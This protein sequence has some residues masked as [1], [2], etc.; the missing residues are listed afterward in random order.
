MFRQFALDGTPAS[1]I[2]LSDE[3]TDVEA[4][5][6][7]HLRDAAVIGAAD[8]L[9]PVSI[10]TGSTLA[11]LIATAWACGTQMDSRFCCGY[12]SRGRKLA[13]EVRP[14]HLA[15]GVDSELA[16]Y[17]VHWTRTRNSAWPDERLIDY[18]HDIIRSESYC[19]SALHTLL[20]ILTTRRILAS[21]RHMPGRTATVSFSALSPG[22]LVPLMRWRARYR[23]MSFEP[24]GVAVHKDCATMLGIRPVAYYDRARE[25]KPTG[26]EPW[27]TQSIGDVT[28]WRQ[29]REYRC[30]GD[31]DL[32]R[33]PAG[34]I[35]AVCYTTEEIGFIEERTGLPAVS[36]T[37]QA[38]SSRS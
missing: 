26:C 34:A 2:A 3:A 5:D 31:L 1:F 36:L 24:Y 13:Y 14:E 12:E 33:V 20:H 21:S 11:S 10:R 4:K 9:L 23:E 6:R 35:K 15:P 25:P 17:L 19:R 37:R 7:L 18:Y 32:R 38:G 8:L 27:L 16:D 29:E 22:E 28:D 30:L